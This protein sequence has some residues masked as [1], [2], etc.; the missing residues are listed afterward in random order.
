M[1]FDIQV[2]DRWEFST[3]IGVIPRTV[4]AVGSKRIAYLNAHGNKCDCSIQ[5]FMRWV[6]GA[7]LS[8][9][10]QSNDDNYPIYEERK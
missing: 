7:E 6:K 3:N 5:T 4:T 2:G 10:L 9:R 8:F 1:T